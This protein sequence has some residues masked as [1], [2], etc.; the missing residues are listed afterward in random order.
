MIKF[1]IDKG[2]PIPKTL[3]VWRKY[4]FLEM[5]IGDSFFV[6]GKENGLRARGAAYQCSYNNNLKFKTRWVDD[7]LRIWRVE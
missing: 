5:E 4:P 6:S 2:I 3:P 7:G 1:E